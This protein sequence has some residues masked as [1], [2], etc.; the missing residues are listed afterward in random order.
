MKLMLIMTELK[1]KLNSLLKDYLIV[2]Q[3]KK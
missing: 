2:K 3:T 1:L